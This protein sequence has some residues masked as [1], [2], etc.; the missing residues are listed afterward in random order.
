MGKSILADKS[1]LFAVRIV[2]LYQYLCKEKHEFVMAKQLLK[3]G[4][5]F[6]AN[7][8]EA[9][10]AVS[11]K[12]FAVKMQIALKEA[13]ESEYW[14]ELLKETEYISKEQYESVNADCG[15]MI[16]MI[17]AS[18]KTAKNNIKE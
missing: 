18:V 13:V 15:E 11:K 8:H 1:K 14:L 17:S 16:K 12:E 4:T 5:S 10:F 3:S 7:V 6:G 9:G 2:R